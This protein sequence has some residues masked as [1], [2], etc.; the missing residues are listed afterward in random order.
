[1]KNYQKTFYVFTFNTLKFVLHRTA[2]VRLKHGLTCLLIYCLSRFACLFTSSM[3]LSMGVCVSAGFYIVLLF[4]FSYSVLLLHKFAS[5]THS[6]RKRYFTFNRQQCFS[7]FFFLMTNSCSYAL[8]SAVVLCKY[9]NQC[10]VTFPS[11]NRFVCSSRTRKGE[12]RAVRRT[13]DLTSRRDGQGKIFLRPYEYC[14]A[15][16]HAQT[17][18]SC[19]QV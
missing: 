4:F 19:G 2:A 3:C 8:R 18:T 7:F 6:Y 17:A 10:S 5:P 14:C 11:P 1:M 15:L 9:I 13:K 12:V 16:R